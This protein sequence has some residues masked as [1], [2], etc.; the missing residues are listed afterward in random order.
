[1]LLFEVFDIKQQNI[2]GFYA[3][4]SFL[5]HK[6]SLLLP[7]NWISN[8]VKCYNSAS[9]FVQKS[10]NLNTVFEISAQA[11][12]PPKNFVFYKPIVP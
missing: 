3:K 1:M 4:C 10:D 12:K 7:V 9:N 11:I 2:S 5:I 8:T 6:N